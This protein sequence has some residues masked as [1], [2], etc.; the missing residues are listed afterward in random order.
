MARRAEPAERGPSLHETGLNGVFGVGS[1]PGQ[2]IGGSK[3]NALIHAYQLLEGALVP[4]PSAL[5]EQDVVGRPLHRPL[6]HRTDG[7]GSLERKG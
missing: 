2:K 7:G 1:R 4:A 6:V 3:G 5:S